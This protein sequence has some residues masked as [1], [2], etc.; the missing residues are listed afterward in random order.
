MINKPAGLLSIQDGYQPSLP[1]V[2]TLLQAEFGRLWIVHRLDRDTSGIL[3]LARTKTAHKH[4]NDQF[5]HREISKTYFAIINGQPAWENKELDQP[6]KVD[7]DHKHRT[8]V[9]LKA[10]KPAVTECALV[11]HL[12][13][14]YALV[15]A[16]PKSGYTHQIRAHL[17]AERFP[18]LNDVLYGKRTQ[19]RDL[20]LLQLALHARS[21]SF[22]H[23]TT[24]QSCTFIA[25]LPVDWIETLKI[26]KS[27]HRWD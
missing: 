19:P 10:G 17:A 14:N 13:Q 9:S 7:G 21:I 22:I 24:G 25:R 5:A 16:H 26:L 1:H 11:E 15:T 27:T 4:L 2:T 23:P 18:I 3:I 12:D 6:L 20:P 8:V